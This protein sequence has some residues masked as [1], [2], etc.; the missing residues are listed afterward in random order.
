MGVVG[1]TSMHEEQQGQFC[2][3]LEG[4]NQGKVVCLNFK[5]TSVAVDYFTWQ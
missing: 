1:V 3:S 5:S 2:T 4:E